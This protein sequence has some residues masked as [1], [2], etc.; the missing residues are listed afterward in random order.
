MTL[1]HGVDSNHIDPHRSD[2]IMSLAKVKTHLPTKLTM[3]SKFESLTFLD[4][5]LT[6]SLL[7]NSIPTKNYALRVPIVPEGRWLRD[8][9]V[10]FE[11]E[12]KIYSS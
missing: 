5:D 2:V 4:F 6:K 11:N 12:M 10:E 1:T 3:D 7:P 9:K 8:E